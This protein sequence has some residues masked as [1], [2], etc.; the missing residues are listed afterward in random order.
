MDVTV[1]ITIPGLLVFLAIG[2]AFA[3]KKV[4]R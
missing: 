2:V 1:T 3:A 4:M